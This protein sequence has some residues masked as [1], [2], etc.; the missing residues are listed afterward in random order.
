MGL[1]TDA[2]LK[3]VKQVDGKQGL[4]TLTML[5]KKAKENGKAIKEVKHTD[6]VELW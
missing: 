6:I 3:T 1:L 2:F 4:K 5:E